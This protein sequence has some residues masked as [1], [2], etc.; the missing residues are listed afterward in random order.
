MWAVSLR[1]SVFDC[2][3]IQRKIWFKCII[4]AWIVYLWIVNRWIVYRELAE[5]SQ[6][7]VQHLVY[8]AYVCTATFINV[9]MILDMYMLTHTLIFPYGFLKF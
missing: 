4:Y 6:S 3:G 8:V 7:R 9:R 2:Y 1:Q 5:L